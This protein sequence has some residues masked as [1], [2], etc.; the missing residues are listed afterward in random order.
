M[1]SIYKVAEDEKNTY[2][3]SSRKSS[4]DDTEQVTTVLYYLITIK[5]QIKPEYKFN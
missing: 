2:V 5:E 4:H 3:S 1:R